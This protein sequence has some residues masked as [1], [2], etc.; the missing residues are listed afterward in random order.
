M[1]GQFGDELN[2]GE[3]GEFG[4]EPDMAH[5][6]GQ[7]GIW[8]ARNFLCPMVESERRHFG[9][10]GLLK[11]GPGFAVA[12]EG[13]GFLGA[14]GSLVEDEYSGAEASH[15]TGGTAVGQVF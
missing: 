10:C 14:G 9:Q 12:R 11:G 4:G 6:I 13:I 3:G 2:R 8:R 15:G 7:H 1:V 5:G